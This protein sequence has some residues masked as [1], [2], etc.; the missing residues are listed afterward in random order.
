MANRPSW[1]EPLFPTFRNKFRG[2]T[3]AVKAEAQGRVRD[4]APRTPL[5]VA[6]AGSPL[7][8]GLE[9]A[10][11]LV[12]LG[13]S[14]PDVI[15]VYLLG[16]VIAAMRFGYF[17][18]ILTSVLSVAAFD[19]FF[20]PPYFDFTVSDKRNLLTF[21]LFLF[22]ACTISNYTE[23]IRRVAI[24]ARERELNE[25]LRSTLLASVSHDLRTPLAVVNG[26]VSALIDCEKTVTPAR[27]REYLQSIAEEASRLNRLVGHLL[28]VTSI[29][30]GVVRLHKDWQSLEELVGVALRRLDEQLAR[31][32]VRVQIDDDAGIVSADATLTE[33]VILNLLENAIKYTPPTSPVEITA[34]RK[35]DDV[36]VTVADRGPGVPAGQEEQIFEKFHRAS[37]TSAGMGLGLT[38]CR[39]ILMAHGGRIWCEN[40]KGGGAS[41]TFVLPRGADD[42][43]VPVLP[44]LIE[45][46]A[47]TS[48][49]S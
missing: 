36:F 25:R 8:V 31:R 49:I 34:R 30:A 23:Q 2:P 11:C 7:L 48:T 39:G 15:I 14:L 9:S 41:F 13:R 19:F 45:E 38:I 35:A 1:L 33:Q 16:V 5:W 12:V 28:D 22:A 10:F 37:R 3:R 20:V 6:A 21:T 4:I 32:P 40:R 44:E 27:R 43:A 17:A 46:A 26:A 29:E 42:E 47:L 18:S 24:L